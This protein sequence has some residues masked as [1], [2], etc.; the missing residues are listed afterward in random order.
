MCA[1]VTTRPGC[2]GLDVAEVTPGYWTWG[3]LLHAGRGAECFSSRESA[4]RDTYC[5]GHDHPDWAGAR[6]RV[7]WA[8][9]GWA[10]WGYAPR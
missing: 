4:E 10:C 2:S 6:A 3:C 9:A 5:S 8:M 7:R 1:D